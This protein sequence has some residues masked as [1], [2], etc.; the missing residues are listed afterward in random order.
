MNLRNIPAVFILVF[1][2]SWAI[3]GI[4]Q[5]N[6][7]QSE[8][9]GGIGLSIDYWTAGKDNITEIAIPFSYILPV[10]EKVRLYAV[11]APAF[12]NLNTGIS[13]GLG[14]MNDIKLG[15][16][17]L[18]FNDAWLFTIGMNL[19]TGKNALETTE[20]TV[21]NILT[22]PA[23]D[24]KVPILGQGFDLQIGLNTAYQIGETSVGCGVSYITKGGFEPIKDY[25][26]EYSPGDEIT[27]TVGADFGKIIGD[28]IYT[29][30]SDDKWGQ[31]EVFRSGNRCVIQLLYSFK[32][33]STDIVIYARDQFKTKNKMGTGDFYE[34]EKKNSN[35]NQF[36][37]LTN[38]YFPGSDKFQLKAMLD[39]KL[40]SNNDYGT[41]AAT[42]T[43]IG[44]GIKTQLSSRVIFDFDLKIFMGRIQAGPMRVNATGLKVYGGFQYIF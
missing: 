27:I 37:I 11:T 15:G 8:T 1:T 38:A 26:E 42:L 29:F 2:F 36:E 24:F 40:Y 25:D 19:P 10:S 9:V 31:E 16:H 18:I 6:R 28:I 17:F 13:Y 5:E 44:G 3:P 34:T 4:T 33:G 39:V 43:G 14:G 35:A 21:A 32:W 41:G 12:T 23:F 7:F 20:Y 22:M 30:Y